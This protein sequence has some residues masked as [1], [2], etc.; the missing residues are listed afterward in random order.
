VRVITRQD[1]AL[2]E[3]GHVVVSLL[4]RT[5]VSRVQV[6]DRGTSWGGLT[7]YRRADMHDHT[8]RNVVERR[9]LTT[10]GGVAAEWSAAGRP[11]GAAFEPPDVFATLDLICRLDDVTDL[12]ESKDAVNGRFVDLVTRA[13]DL[14]EANW[15]RVARIATA[16]ATETRLDRDRILALAS[17]PQVGR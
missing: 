7:S 8:R 13:A 6:I 12:D 17:D 14:L 4:L 11:E 15:Q 1:A 16:L 5:G 2:H 10:V 9:A 3:A